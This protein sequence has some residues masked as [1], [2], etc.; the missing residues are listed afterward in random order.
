MQREMLYENRECYSECGDKFISVKQLWKCTNPTES[1]YINI[2]Y[3]LAVVGKD[4]FGRLQYDLISKV[5]FEFDKKGNLRF[6]TSKK[7]WYLYAPNQ[8]DDY[9]DFYDDELNVVYYASTDFEREV[10]DFWAEMVKCIEDK[11]KAT[12][13][14]V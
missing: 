7:K 11:L 1:I 2:F 8:N 6:D 9:D 4:D 14:V 5:R 12:Y 10:C 3:K 13:E